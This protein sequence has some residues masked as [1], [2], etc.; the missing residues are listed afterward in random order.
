MIPFDAWSLPESFRIRPEVATLP[1]RDDG[2][3]AALDVRRPLL[4]SAETRALV[5]RLREARKRELVG[6]G[7]HEVVKVIDRV[8]ARFLD[9]ADPLHREAMELLPLSSG[10][11]VPMA[12]L[13]LEGMARDWTEGRL[14]S[15]LAIELGDPRVLDDLRPARGGGATRAIGYPLTLHIAAGTVPGVSVTS[16]IRG[17]LVKSAVLLKPG[18]GDIVLP[19]LFA[20][21]LERE[22][23]GI[24]SALAV[25]YWPGGS[26]DIEDPLLSNA[27]LVIAYG[28]DD[29][30]QSWRTRMPATTPLVAYPHR[31]GFAMIGREKL[32][33]E[34]VEALSAE[35]ARAVATFDQRGCVSPHLVY[36]EEGGAVSPE[37]WAGH[38]VAAFDLLEGEL[39][40]GTPTAKE[41]SAVH[42]LRGAAEIEAA[43]GRGV[44]VHSGAGLSWTVIYDPDP[45]FEA[46][47]L[48]RTLRVKPVKEL[49]AV[50]R[51]VAPVA[52]HLQS[53][54]MEVATGR[55][56]ALA[57]PL[58]ELGVTRAASLRT[59][60]WPPPWWHHDG[61]GPLR[62][63]L[64]WSDLEGE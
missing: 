45:A 58:F 24:G 47:C 25:L 59:L 3:D 31:V 26:G 20:R 44:K 8:A 16:L 2:G 41:A 30:I 40:M 27:D 22:D 19:V 62:V 29:T 11:S 33:A 39:P 4:S 15:L 48:G 37:A 17:L 63:L 51:L 36:V 32:T 7:V 6:R 54:G 60:P 53:V 9:P 64:R 42:Q 21:A 5:E 56:A 61:S 52:R 10:L 43:A 55:R 12:R 14:R 13:V 46:S 23:S 28:S 34:G 35:M 49:A 50:P 18:L 57:A 1:S 38:L